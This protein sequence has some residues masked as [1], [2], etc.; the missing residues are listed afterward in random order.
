M[1][2]RRF[3]IL[4][5]LAQLALVS[6][7]AAQTTQTITLMSGNGSI[8]SGDPAVE[9]SLDDGVTWPGHACIVNKHPNY[10]GPIAGTNYIN[11]SCSFLSSGP[12]GDSV[13]YRIPFTL[14]VDYS[15]PSF[16]IDVHADNVAT[17]LLNACNVGQQTFAE[18][19]A[20]FQDP[21]EQFSTTQTSCFLPGLNYLYVDLHNF[22][23]AVALDFKATV[24]VTVETAVLIDIKPGS[25]PNNI[26]C[27]SRGV[28]PLAI[29]STEEF[30]A[31]TVDPSTVELNGVKAK[32]VGKKGQSM[33]HLEDVDSD[34]DTDMVC[35]I[36]TIDFLMDGCDIS[37]T[38]ILRAQT[39]AGEHVVG[40]DTVRIVP[41][42]E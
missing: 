27:N 3:C 17:I 35:H 2:S 5:V 39:S 25:F 6:S 36:P 38:A 7:G 23:S 26:G 9:Y 4:L 28:I 8:G 30:D 33:C 29:L 19:V 32:V 15:N 10:S 20:N 41:E 1:N 12:F 34:G 11:W 18:V 16:T 14:P 21:A 22:S 31:T 13:R 42:T 24:V 37:E 40:Q